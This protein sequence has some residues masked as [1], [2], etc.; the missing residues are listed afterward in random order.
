MR[1]SLLKD[2][3]YFVGLCLSDLYPCDWTWFELGWVY[4][5][6]NL[7]I[8]KSSPQ[9]W[10][11]E[12][13]CF[14]LTWIN[15]KQCTRIFF[16]MQLYFCCCLKGLINLSLSGQTAWFNKIT[17]DSKPQQVQFKNITT[18][19]GMSASQSQFLLCRRECKQQNCSLYSSWHRYSLSI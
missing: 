2:M 13:V 5:F 12:I 4:Q 1:I 6:C 17:Q 7:E 15:C 3:A 16:I 18:Y 11:Q 9:I 14:R 8:F 10:P 19:K